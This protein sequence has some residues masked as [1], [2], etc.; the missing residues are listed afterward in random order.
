MKTNVEYRLGDCGARFFTGFDAVLRPKSG[1]SVQQVVRCSEPS[2]RFDASM[3][4]LENGGL[5]NG[6]IR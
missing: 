5:K 6:G 3:D 2:N 4:R 1:I